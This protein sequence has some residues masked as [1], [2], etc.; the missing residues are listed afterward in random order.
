V[1][2]ASI[3]PVLLGDR[4]LAMVPLKTIRVAIAAIFLLVGFIVAIGAL[5]LT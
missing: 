1:I 2:A 3:A 5:R 4:L